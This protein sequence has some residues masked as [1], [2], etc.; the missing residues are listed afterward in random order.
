[1]VSE[2]V[3]IPRLRVGVFATNTA[4]ELFF[5]QAVGR[6]VRWTRGVLPEGVLL[7]P[8]RPTLARPHVPRSPTPAGTCCAP[9]RRCGPGACGPQPD[10]AE[11]AAAAEVVEQLSLF[12]VLSA[13]ATGMSVHTFTE[14]GLTLF[15]DEPDVPEPDGAADDPAA[16]VELR[17]IPTP[18]GYPTPGGSASPSARSRSAERNFKLARALVDRTGWSHGRVNAELNHQVG[19]TSVGNATNEQLERRL[20]RAEA[21][22]AERSRSGARR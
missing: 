13:V 4:T 12:S 17:E 10:L 18:A 22:L 8:R 19:L 7:H 6:L 16:V 9:G 11:E 3:D 5:R 15:D 14:S 21:W 1:M 2:G 20:R